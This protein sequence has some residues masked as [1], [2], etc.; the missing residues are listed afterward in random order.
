MKQENWYHKISTV[1][2]KIIDSTLLLGAILGLIAFFLG[3]INYSDTSVKFLYLVDFIIVIILIGVAIFRRKIPVEIKSLII[4][5]GLYIVIINDVVKLGFYSDSKI[6]LVIIP[7]YSFLVYNLRKSLIIYTIAV[8]SFMLIGALHFTN[9]IEPNVDLLDR[10]KRINPWIINLVL[11]TIVSFVVVVIMKRFNTGYINLIEDLEERNKQ[12]T[13]KE[14]NYR[15]IF[16]AS[17]DAIFIHDLQGNILD[18]NKSMLSMY[19]YDKEE[20]SDI[21]ISH[22]SSGKKEYSAETAAVMVQQAIAGKEPV[23]DWQA[24]KKNGEYFWVEVALK[25]T[26]IGNKDRVLAIIR[27]INEKKEDAMQLIL[28]RNHLKELVAQR[29]KELEQA[30]KEL[31]TS[32]D[33][34]AQ[35][36]EELVSTLNELES[37]QEQLIH[38]EK[39]ASL[40]V[41]AS[42]VAHEINNPLNFIKG[43]SI[44]LENFIAEELPEKLETIKP[45][46]N[47]INEG[48]KRATS[49]VTSLNHYSREGSGTEEVC[50]IHTIIDN[51]LVMLKNQTKNRIKIK[52]QFCEEVYN[53]NGNEGRLHQVILNI[54]T[55]S[56]QSINEKGVISINTRIENKHILVSIKDNGTGISE[57]NLNKIFDPFFT[58]KEA[59]EGTGLG[60][61]ISLRII[62]AH[63]GNIEY[64]S[65]L[66]KDTEAIITLPVEEKLK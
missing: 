22:L 30:N 10:A 51:C 41:L 52:K 32:N 44:G 26:K 54:L 55:N 24:K 27:D 40:G 16:D 4:I 43:G 28:Y 37:A 33:K 18:V 8:F 23:F 36:K 19:G 13:E 49:I 34:L 45:L 17:T 2:V 12:I 58:T 63:N 21:N 50:D 5:S 35:Q 20:V 62:Q 59:G 46:L 31:L 29:T 48:V 56:I 66:N 1:T 57:N 25:K 9:V 7:F 11:I 3:L 64:K 15:E 38:S 42:G 61:S 39:M 60:L 14:Q 6:L 47:G 65:A 53:L